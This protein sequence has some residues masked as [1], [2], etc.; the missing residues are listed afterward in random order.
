[1]DARIIEKQIEVEGRK[2]SI[3]KYPAFVSIKIGKMLISKI[4]PVFQSFVP[5]IIELV[6]SDTGGD[7]PQTDTPD[8]D[9]QEDTVTEI[10]FDVMDAP[11]GPPDFTAEQPPETDPGPSLGGNIMGN[12][13]DNIDQYLNFSSISEALDQ[14]SNKDM[15]YI[16][17]Q[18]LMCCYEHLRAGP[19]QVIN[20]V[21]RFGVQDLERDAPLVLRLVI[22]SAM[23]GLS[24]F[25][26]VS[27]LK[28]ILNL[29]SISSLSSPLT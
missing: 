16:M 29:P 25:F 2:F 19:V 17:H 15:D 8:E 9:G 26:T 13:L 3:Y 5:L 18:S 12:V 14:V 10:N 11:S 24:D 28:S 27:R 7:S 6:K 23:W 20:S 4:L 21:G 1:M 22:E